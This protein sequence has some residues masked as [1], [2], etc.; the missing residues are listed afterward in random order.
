MFLP[1]FSRVGFA[2]RACKDGDAGESSLLSFPLF[3]FLS[4]EERSEAERERKKGGG[5]ERNEEGNNDWGKFHEETVR[6]VL[7]Q[8]LE[9]AGRGPI[10]EDG[11]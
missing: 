8:L 9:R 11:K 10:F 3:S 5:W 7:F 1:S 6:T 4:D 2:P